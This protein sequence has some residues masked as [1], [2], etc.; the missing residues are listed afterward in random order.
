MATVAVP[1]CWRLGDRQ[2]AACEI[3]SLPRC[4]VFR[5]DGLPS[6]GD[7]GNPPR[8]RH[9][10][11]LKPQQRYAG[12][13]HTHARAHTHTHTHAHTHAHTRAH[14]HTHKQTHPHTQPPPHTHTQARAR[15]APALSITTP[16]PPLLSR[17]VMVRRVSGAVRMIN[18]WSW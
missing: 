12:D 18:R 9:S 10:S 8:S 17:M 15:L 3:R 6:A 1:R 5:L 7:S 11:G 4:T 14:R 16:P 2:A 13:K